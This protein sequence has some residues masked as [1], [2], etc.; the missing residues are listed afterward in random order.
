[1]WSW[2]GGISNISCERKRVRI[3][4][5]G[6]KNHFRRQIA[7]QGFHSL[8]WYFT[9]PFK[10]ANSLQLDCFSFL[11]HTTQNINLP[12]NQK[13]YVRQIRGY[14]RK[15]LD[16]ENPELLWLFLCEFFFISFQII[17]P[18]NV[19][20]KIVTVEPNSPR[21]ILLCRDLRF[22]W[23]ALSCWQ[24]NCLV[25]LWNQAGVRALENLNAHVYKW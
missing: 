7:A 9:Q 6:H 23:G 8:K 12:T 21:K 11:L 3:W 10:L 19:R 1:M 2:D 22:F 16:K 5:W 17:F 4:H 13:G 14:V 18:N 20:T 25:I 15:T 24:I